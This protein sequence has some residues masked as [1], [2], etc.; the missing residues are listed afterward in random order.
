MERQVSTTYYYG[1]LK[2]E[3]SVETAGIETMSV[4]L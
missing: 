4:I 1:Y 2:W 3:G